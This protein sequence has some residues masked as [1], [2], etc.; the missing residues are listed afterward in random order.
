MKKLEQ[1]QRDQDGYLLNL[2]DWNKQLATELACEEN[3][4][5]TDEHWMIINKARE[6]YTTYNMSPAIRALVNFLKQELGA[7]KGNSIYLQQLFHLSPAKQ[8]S[9]IAGLPKP[10]RCT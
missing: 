2:T 1:I 4:T 6:F 10:I 8:I 5:L 3:I 7:D 9:K